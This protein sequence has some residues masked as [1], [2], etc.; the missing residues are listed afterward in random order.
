MTASQGGRSLVKR[1]LLTNLGDARSGCILPHPDFTAISTPGF[2]WWRSL[3]FPGLSGDPNRIENAP[4]PAG[5]T[6]RIRPGLFRRRGDNSGER[7]VT[8]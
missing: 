3:G 6:N 1:E 4:I 7:G 2:N 5:Q 8:A